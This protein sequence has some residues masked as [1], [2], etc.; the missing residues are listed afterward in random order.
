MTVPPEVSSTLSTISSTV[1]MLRR[2]GQDRLLLHAQD[3]GH[4]DVALSV[5]ALGVDDRHVRPVGGNRRQLLAGEG[6]LDGSDVGVDLGIIGS[7]IALEESARHPRRTR[8]VGVGHRGVRVLLEYHLVR[9]GLFIG[10]AEA[11]ER[12]HARVPAPR[13]DELVGTPHPDHLVVDDVRRHPDQG[14]AADPLAD[15]LGPGGVRDEVGEAFRRHRAPR[16][17]VSRDGL[18]EFQ[19]FGHAVALTTTGPSQVIA[20]SLSEHMFALQRTQNYLPRVPVSTANR[21]KASVR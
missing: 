17:D 12:A 14:E 15:D 7:S 19:K 6:A 13:E 3:P 21:A 2:R 18:G 20:C 4:P 9:H 8:G 1:T 5:R 16:F 11:E 10:V